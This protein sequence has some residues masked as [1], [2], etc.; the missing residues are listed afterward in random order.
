MG[1][2]DDIKASIEFAAMFN[3]SP[4][5]TDQDVEEIPGKYEVEKEYSQIVAHAIEIRDMEVK[6]GRVSLPVA[7]G[8]AFEGETVR[9]PQTYVECGGPTKTKVFELV[10]IRNADAVKDG[11]ITLIGKDVDEMDE[12]SV[13]ALGILV[14]VYGKHMKKEFEPVVERRIHQFINYA[15]G[16]WHT[17]QRNLLWVRLSKQSVENGLRFTHFGHILYAKMKEEFGGL[18]SRLQV[19]IIT[20]EKDVEKYLPE[21]SSSYAE[22]DKG[23]A[24]LTDESVNEFYS[25]T[26][27]Q[28]FAPCH[29]CIISPERLGLCGALNWLDA[30]AGYSIDPNGPNKPVEKG[31]VIDEQKGQWSNVNKA[32]QELTHGHIERMN[33]YTMMEDPQTSCGCFE[34]IIAISSDLQGVIA[35]N[36]EYTGMTPIGMKF[37]TLAG[38]VGGGT[39]IPGFIGV[40]RQFITSKKFIRADGGIARIVWMPK[41]L[42]AAL[43]ENLEK[44]AK[45]VGIP[46][47]VE[48]IADETIATNAEELMEYLDKINHPSL[49]M[50]PMGT[51]ELGCETGV[52]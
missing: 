46:D 14:E 18:I 49:N 10:K 2:V 43:R 44:W 32:V 9:K 6:F 21:A 48:K 36:R 11:Q 30:A 22:R 23:V 52:L 40:G 31:A 42:K 16:A 17:G 50:L 15:E 8:L 34:C 19:T 33:Q 12:G 39:Q 3:G 41:E 1:P 35:V 47:L 37:S 24:G 5:I 7:Y 27:C 38:L 29:V 51:L 13:S 45:E 28:S 4:T 25:C 20:D 26:L